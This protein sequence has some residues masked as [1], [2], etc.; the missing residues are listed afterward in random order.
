MFNV[1][2]A[3]HAKGNENILHQLHWQIRGGHWRR[4]PNP[5]GPFFSILCNSLGKNGHNNRFA[6]PPCGWRSG[7]SW[8]RH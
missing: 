6:L 7:K 8:I 1:L 3:S 4:V 2:R 5:L